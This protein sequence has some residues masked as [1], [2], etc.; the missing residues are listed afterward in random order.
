MVQKQCEWQRF[1]ATC[2]NLVGL[3]DRPRQPPAPRSAAGRCPDRHLDR[4]GTSV[5]TNGMGANEIEVD[6][7][8]CNAVY[9]TSHEDQQAL[10]F[11]VGYL[12]G[13]QKYCC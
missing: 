12:H 7:K 13:S 5:R 4:R 1:V 3:A 11:K 10:F 2:P 6:G 8:C 9:A